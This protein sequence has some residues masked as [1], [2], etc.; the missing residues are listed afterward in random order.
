MRL[1]AG[2]CYTDNEFKHQ[3][4]RVINT[5]KEWRT[6]ELRMEEVTSGG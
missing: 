4:Q 3:Q 5:D 1:W 2:V 6:E